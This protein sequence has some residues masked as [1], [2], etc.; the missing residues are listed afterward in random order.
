[1]PPSAV[2]LPAPAIGAP[3]AP[4]VPRPERYA[5]SNGLRVVAARMGELPQVVLRLVVPAGAAA[6]PREQPGTAAMV[7]HLLTEGTELHT[8]GELNA[9]IDYLGAL[10]HAH[11]GHDYAEAE[12]VLLHETLEEG[13]QLLAEVITRP[14]FPDAEVERI[15]N[16]SLDAL[17]AREDEPGNVADDRT[18]LAVFGAEHPYGRPSF[19]TAE[20]IAGVTRDQLVAFHEKHYRPVGSYLVVAGDF[21]P[22]ALREMLEAAF[23][24]WAG[25]APP[26]EYPADP[27]P[28]NG[29]QIVV[30]WEDA[31]QSEIRIAGLGIDRRSPDWVCGA[32]A[33]YILGGST[34]TGRLG[35]NLREE[36]GWT[37]GAN[38]AFTAGVARGGWTAHTAVDVEVT[39]AAVQEMLREMRR[40]AEELVDEGELR[41][42][43]DAMVLSL[44]RAFETPGQVASRLGTLEAYGLAPDYWERYPAAVQAVTA[45]DVRRIAR[46]R[47]HPDRVVRVVVGG[48]MG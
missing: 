45:E 35:A 12:A 15:R 40:M 42:A 33:N 3:P 25:E 41:R 29:E 23:A 24:G 34:I 44:P 46:E 7:G 36:K 21:E 17:V 2:F 30:E 13:I 9:R 47:F 10:L 5:L 48:G 27:G 14:A 37:Y 4:R 19:G 26:V 6:E 28:L 11:V 16:E 39:G 18:S 1:M 43:R 32:V 22:G 38:S 20:G 8:A 31:A